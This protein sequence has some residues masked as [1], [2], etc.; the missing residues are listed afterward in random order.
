MKYYKQC[1]MCKQDHIW[2]TAFLPVELA[3]A[4][5]AVVVD[6]DPVVWI[7]FSVADSMVDEETLNSWRKQWK[8]FE[9]VLS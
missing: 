8:D 1:T 9:Q 7:I 5:K 3:K 6:G 4:G 2:Q